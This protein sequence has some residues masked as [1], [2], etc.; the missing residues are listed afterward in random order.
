MSTNKE[1]F[2]DEFVRQ[3]LST[4]ALRRLQDITFLGAIDYLQPSN[5]KQNHRRRNNR[6]EH[7]LG[8]ARLVAAYCDTQRMEAKDF[9]PL[10]AAALLHDVGHG[11]LSHTLEPIFKTYFG[12]DHHTVGV[13]YVRGKGTIG[14]EL[15]HFFRLWQVDREQVIEIIQGTSTE[16]HSRLFSSTHNVDTIEAI[17]R[18]YSMVRRSL[19]PRTADYYFNSIWLGKSPSNVVADDFWRLKTLFITY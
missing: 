17:T 3:L 14:Q 16:K 11:P 13:S 5:G 2:N 4:K 7:T 15:D 10:I 12:L 1:T 18:S 8:V 9:R 6:F 19:A